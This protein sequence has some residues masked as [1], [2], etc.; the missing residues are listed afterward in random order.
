MVSNL[1]A[2]IYSHKV[3]SY[4]LLTTSVQDFIGPDQQL[5]ALSH[6]RKLPNAYVRYFIFGFSKFISLFVQ[7]KKV[8][9]GKSAFIPDRM[10][11]YRYTACL[12]SRIGLWEKYYCAPF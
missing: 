6:A 10:H 7:K 11:S 2:H 3:D 12:R 9:C 4:V 1:H 5:K 8:R